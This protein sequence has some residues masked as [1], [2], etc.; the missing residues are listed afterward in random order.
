MTSLHR[1][2]SRGEADSPGGVAPCEGE[3]AQAGVAGWWDRYLPPRGLERKL[4]LALVALVLGLKVL[5]IYHY[6]ADADEPQHAYVVWAWATGHLQYRDVFD[7]HMPLFQMACVP[8]MALLGPRANIIILLR[9][10]MMPLYFVS[11]WCVFRIAETLFS[12][13]IAPW[14]ALIAGALPAFFY[15]STEF[16]PD[17]LWAVFWLMALLVGVSGTFTVRRA[18]AFGLLLGLTFAVSMKTVVLVAGLLTATLVALGLA[19]LRG[20]GPGPVKIASRLGAILVAAVIPT[21]ALVLFFASRGA[22]WIMYYCVVAHNVVPRMKR[23]GHISIHEWIFPISLVVLGVYGWFLF[24]QTRDTRLAMRRTIILLTPCF[25]IALLLSYWPDITREDDLPYVPLLPLLGVPIL[26]GV[27][28]WVRFPRVEARFFTWI[29]PV[30]CFAELIW[31][32]NYDTLRTNRMK[33]TTRSIEDVLLLTD[34]NDYV[35][36]A[37][38]NYIFRPRPYYWVFETITKVRMRMGLIK[39]TLPQALEKTETKVC[40]LYSAHIIPET[41]RFILTNYIPFDTEA[42]D[43]GVA[44]KELPKPAA[45]GTYAFDVA[46]PTTYAVVSESGTTAG[47]LDGAPYA[48]P[49]RIEAGHHLFH[50][51]AGRGRVAIFLDRALAEGFHPLFDASEKFIRIDENGKHSSIPE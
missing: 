49:V 31:V 30:V 16:R 9:W 47:T 13:R 51:T 1:T 48:G 43:L 41:N 32:W 8:L 12:R 4:F 33:V 42:L 50:R 40:Y 25:F 44:G 15:T 2:L 11:L 6:R 28:S 29:L 21:G 38:G 20:D 36:D 18:L 19:W 46:I 17:D 37:R 10:A 27:A 5:T 26:I 3:P 35:M 7:N 22:F 24:R 45:D 14:A 34:P 23:W 39:D